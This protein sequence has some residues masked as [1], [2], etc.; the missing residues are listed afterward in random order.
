MKYL[1]S[2]FFLI[3]VV[4]KNDP[5]MD[6]DYEEENKGEIGGEKEVK[7]DE[8]EPTTPEEG[9]EDGKIEGEGEVAKLSEVKI[10]VAKAPSKKES[11][12]TITAVIKSIKEKV[13][14]SG[15]KYLLLGLVGQKNNVFVFPYRVEEERWGELKVGK[16]YK[17]YCEEKEKDGKGLL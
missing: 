15:S 4:D 16:S 17:F 9:K 11:S 2:K 8:V 1:L 5:D 10:E 13:D 7:T 6:Q 14:T 3:S 12:A